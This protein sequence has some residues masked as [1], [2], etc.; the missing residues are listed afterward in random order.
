[1][2]KIM[3]S[4]WYN[5]IKLIV[6]A[7]LLV[8]CEDV[9][10]PNLE[11][12]DP[13]L[14]I[15]AWVTNKPGVQTIK[16]NYTVAYD[17][18][19]QLPPAAS[20][21]LVQVTASTGKVYNFVENTTK[22]DGSYEWTPSTASETFGKIGERYTLSVVL[23]GETFIATS[24][25]AAVP[26]VDSLVFE[27]EDTN[28]PR[29]NKGYQAEFWARDLPGEGNLYWIRAYKNS[30]PLSKPDEINTSY[31]GGLAAGSGND[32]RFFLPPI[33]AGVNPRDE[34]ADGNALSPYQVNDSL[35]VETHSL[36]IQSFNYLKEV[37]DNT[38][39]QTGFASL[40]SKPMTNVSTNIANQ[41][42]VGSQVVGFF[43][44]AAV[45]GRGKKF[46]K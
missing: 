12:A 16:L 14:S 7:M 25:M 28:S 46:K 33:R 13:I 34:D 17:D 3:K 6:A 8:A 35:Y 23:K 29:G 11:K 20:T 18:N 37:K 43:N 15:D 9:I 27:Y 38:D 21:A 32:G 10:D 41:N 1:M 4:V 44:V 45:S 42:P 31:D 39:R 22:K 2:K 36:T 5:S 30:I 24:S 26:S 40:F 19:S